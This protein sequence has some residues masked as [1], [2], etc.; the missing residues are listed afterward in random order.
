MRQRGA[1]AMKICLVYVA[2]GVAG[3]N[4][5]RPLGDLE[6]GWI[7]HGIA[8]IGACV[9]HAGYD[10]TLIDMRQLSGPEEFEELVSSLHCD[11]YG[12]S[13]APIDYKNSIMAAK[14]IRKTCP[15]AKIVVG[16]IH[17]TLF[18]ERYSEAKGGTLFDV[19]VVGE[20]EITFIDILNDMTKGKKIPKVVYGIKP[21][22]D[23][24]PVVDRELFDYKFELNGTFIPGQPL[25]SVTILAGRGCPY[26]C[27]YCQPAENSVFGKPFRIRSAEKVID[28]LL[29]LKEKY[30]HKNIIFW[31]DTFTFDRKWVMKFCDL[32]ENAGIG[33]SIIACSRS[34]II[35]KNEDMIK[36]LAEIGLKWFVIGFESGSQRLLD[37]IKKGITVEQNIRAAEI[38]RKYG[39]KI[40]GT[41]MYGLPTETPEESIET[42]EMIKTIKPDQPMPFWFVPIEGTEIYSMCKDMNIIIEGNQTV[43]RTGKYIPRLKGIDYE[44]LSGILYVEAHNVELDELVVMTK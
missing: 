8:S 5:N 28:E 34:N 13:T 21:D 6:G 26:K 18:P 25:P 19:V 24:I 17:P 3:F 43:E 42:L 12:L 1:G 38:C 11:V 9:K 27:L 2:V 20:G 29:C 41:Y 31:D 40:I 10:L 37:M 30:H 4:K 16:G 7:G 35:C 15:D 14:V 23:R 22:L 32:Y 36:R 39:I 44:L 33:S